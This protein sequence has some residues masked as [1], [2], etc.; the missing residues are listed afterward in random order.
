[1]KFKK[2]IIFANSFDNRSWTGHALSGGDEILINYIKFLEKQKIDIKIYTWQKGYEI[3]TNNDINKDSIISYHSL[4]FDKLG[5][6]AFYLYRLIRIIFISLGIKISS[7]DKNSTMIFSSSDFV[8]DIIP[9]YILSKKNKVKMISAFY[10]LAPNPFKGNSPYKN[11][12]QIFSF[13]YWVLQK[14]S[15]KITLNNSSGVVVCSE[16]A[17]NYLNSKSSKKIKYLIIH[18][19][20]DLKQLNKSFNKYGDDNKI[21]DACFFGRL[22]PQ[23]GPVEMIKIWKIV[24]S[25]KPFAK[26]AIIGNGTE[27]KKIKTLI[28][29]YN[30][31]K[32]IDLK[33]YVFGEPKDRI[34]LSSKIM[35]HPAIYDTGGMAVCQGMSFGNPA[36]SFDLEGLKYTYPKGMVKIH[37]Y[38]CEEF[39][40]E[41]IRLLDD[42]I[43]YNKFKKDAIEL[44]T[45]WGWDQRGKEFNIFLNSII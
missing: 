35:A 6:I 45:S 3:L 28:S 33:G 25:F 19:G 42:K 44:A 43:Y 26:L 1:M 11:L 29:E 37:C 21:Y 27:E 4:Y 7:E 32:N 39:A 8:T 41:I 10:L 14:I 22:H 13:F 40:N 20:L 15:I 31:K 34:L 16:L 17:I 23:K 18:G 36:V 38:D 30:M 9:A 5:F 24:V 2:L 12:A